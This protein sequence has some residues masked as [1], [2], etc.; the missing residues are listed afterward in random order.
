MDNRSMNAQTSSMGMEKMGRVGK[1]G[2]K[3]TE[4]TIHFADYD[5]K[6]GVLFARYLN[7]SF[8]GSSKADNAK[9]ANRWVE[10]GNLF[11][12]CVCIMI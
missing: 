12:C 10:L 1:L 3:P 5:K 8:A 4:S 7:E 11:R 6:K 2:S 9:F